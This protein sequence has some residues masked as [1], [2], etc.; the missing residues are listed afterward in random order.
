MSKTQ[1]NNWPTFSHRERLTTKRDETLC[2]RGLAAQ[3]TQPPKSWLRSGP[4]TDKGGRQASRVCV[5]TAVLRPYPGPLPLEK[6]VTL[7]ACHTD[8]G[9][10]HPSQPEPTPGS[11]EEAKKVCAWRTLLAA[12]Q[13]QGRRGAGKAET[14]SLRMKCL[15]C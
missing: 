9:R 7:E 11:L 14:M 8:N 5:H 15:T 10:K 13:P 6:T 1:G 3:V 4:E 2:L 12:L